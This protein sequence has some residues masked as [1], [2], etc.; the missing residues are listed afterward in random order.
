MK[1]QDNNS[2]VN[3][4]RIIKNT[5]FL[6]IRML[7]LMFISL[8]T[9]R[10]VLDNLGILDFGI[11]NIVGGFATMF[12]FFR[13]SLANVTQR[14][15]S[16]ELG[17]HDEKAAKDIFCIHQSVYIIVS[18]LVLVVGEILGTWF[19]YYKMNIPAERLSAAFW[20]FQFTLFSLCTTILSVVYEAVIIA[21]EEMKIYSYVGI[22]EGLTKLGI[23]MII[24]VV[25]YDKLIVYSFLLVMVAIGIRFF[26]S[27][28]CKRRYKECVYKWIWNRDKI[29][30]CSS[31]IGWNTMG[32]LIYTINDQGI[33]I[34]LNLFFGPIINAARGIAFQINQAVNNFGTNFYISVRPQIVKLYATKDFNHLFKLFFSSSKLSVYLLWIICLPLCLSIDTILHLWLKEVPAYTNVFTILILIYSIV[35]VLNNPIWSLALA[36]GKLKNYILI[37]SS[38]LLFIFPISYVF[39]KLGS[40]PQ[41][42]FVVSIIIRC[43]YIYV[44]L[45]F[46]KKEINFSLN[47]YFYEVLFPAIIVIGI[48]GGGCYWLNSGFN[49]SISQ[50]A[51]ITI[52][53]I[54]ITAI[55][56]WTLGLKG[57]ERQ[58]IKSIFYDKI[59]RNKHE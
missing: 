39:L 54:L 19:I 38:V 33:N 1:I 20:V 41:T 59:Q 9:S 29:K 49:N 46:I 37:G 21:R 56:I 31:M 13:S 3:N 24:S 36:I 44:V 43:A 16:I 7:F 32:T 48:S 14:Y 45:F 4:K 2:A 17:K 52:A 27:I 28:Y 42:V 10:V 6:Y 22:F 53:T 50:R 25:T 12:I 18:I 23:A 5:L 58:K 30:E 57:T 55:T 11:Y 26:Y 34:L 35:D 15:L 8:Y 47:S 40:T 51:F